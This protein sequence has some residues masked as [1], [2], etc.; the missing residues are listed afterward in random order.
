MPN[1]AKIGGTENAG[2]SAVLCFEA[3]FYGV[4]DAFGVQK[5]SAT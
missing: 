5:T 3:L 1:R 2:G 4:S